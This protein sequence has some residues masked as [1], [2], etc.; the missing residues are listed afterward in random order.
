[1]VSADHAIGQDEATVASHQ[2]AS[3]NFFQL[4]PK[5]VGPQNQRH[6]LAALADCLTG[7]ARLAVRGTLIVRRIEAVDADDLRPQFRSLIE[8]GTADCAEADDHDVRGVTHPRHDATTEQAIS[9]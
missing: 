2:S 6:E 5:L 8:R 4:F 7:D 3:S 1:M 9:N